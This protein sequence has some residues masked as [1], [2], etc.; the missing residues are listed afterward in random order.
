VLEVVYLIFNEGHTASA[1]DDWTRPEL[2]GDALRLAR[3]LAQIAPDEPEVHGLAAL[4]ELQSARLATRVDADGNPVL[5]L[6]QDRSRW[7]RFLIRRGLDALARAEELGGATG[8]YALQ[9]GIAAA[10]ARAV[11][12]EDTD[13]SRIATLYKLLAL[14]R[15]SPIVELNRAV[16]VGMA[17]GPAAGLEIVDALADEPALAGYHLLPS[18]RADLLAKLGRTEEAA[19]ELARAAGL[20]TNERERALLAARAVQ[21]G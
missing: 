12:A 9:A 13:W 1:G 7:D 6:D 3:L 18:V 16:A 8:P 14:V 20:A 15:P 19:A 21:L 11:R 10:H 17:D 2:C 4:L 5:L